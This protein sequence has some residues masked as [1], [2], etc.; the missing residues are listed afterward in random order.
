HGALVVPID[1]ERRGQQPEGRYRIWDILGHLLR[2]LVPFRPQ[3]RF[4]R[5]AFLAHRPFT[6]RIRSCPLRTCVSP[7]IPQQSPHLEAVLRP[8]PAPPPA[9]LV[10]DG[11]GPSTG[12]A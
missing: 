2:A 8:G 12:P 11:A 7:C 5:N 10:S 9:G 3:P 6:T 4:D 1:K